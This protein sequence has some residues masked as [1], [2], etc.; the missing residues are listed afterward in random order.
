LNWLDFILVL[1]IGASTV[2]G[3]MKGFIKIGIGFAAVV[4]G[5][6]C[7]SWTYG[8]V[9]ASLEPYV[10]SKNVA[11]I[12]GFLAVLAA[13]MILGA[14]ISALLGKLFRWVGLSWIDRLGGAAFGFARGMVI[15]VVLVMILLA[16]SPA[17]IHESV[18]NSSIAPYVVETSRIV[19]KATPHEIKDGFR[20]GYANVKI[21]WKQAMKKKPRSSKDKPQS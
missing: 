9:G 7:A 13:I 10:G 19:S 12:L 3:F 11:K 21:V 16:F 5:F 4:I 15:S 18:G 20:E 17:A 8:T 2:S 1:I 14:L 6:V